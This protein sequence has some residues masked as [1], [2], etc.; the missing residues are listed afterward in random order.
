MKDLF[1]NFNLEEEAKELIEAY[2]M[3]PF[4]LTTYRLGFYKCGD[5]LLSFSCYNKNKLPDVVRN[6]KVEYIIDMKEDMD[7]IFSISSNK[8]DYSEKDMNEAIKKS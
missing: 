2:F 8:N 7:S 4:N 3:K 1:K 6:S 5:E